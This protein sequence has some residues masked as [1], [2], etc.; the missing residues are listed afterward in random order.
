MRKF[1]MDFKKS[2]SGRSNV[3]SDDVISYRPG[4]SCSKGG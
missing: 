4:T 3:R 1:E 2:F